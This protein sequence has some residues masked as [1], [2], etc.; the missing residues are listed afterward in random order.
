MGVRCSRIHGTGTTSGF[1]SAPRRGA[2][3]G[4]IVIAINR[5]SHTVAGKPSLAGPTSAV[6]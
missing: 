4:C 5:A 3:S 2:A 6:G 1:I